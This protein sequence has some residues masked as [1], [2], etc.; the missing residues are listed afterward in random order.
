MSQMG[1]RPDGNAEMRAKEFW[2]TAIAE[3]MA[4]PPPPAAPA[5]PGAHAYLDKTWPPTGAWLR[6]ARR[7]LRGD[8]GPELD[9]KMVQT[10]CEISVRQTDDCAGAIALVNRTIAQAGLHEPDACK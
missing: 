10:L 6:Q 1:D 8:R 4:P 5:K 9:A 2:S 7:V 3:R